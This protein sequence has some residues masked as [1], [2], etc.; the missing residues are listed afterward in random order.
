MVEGYVDQDARHVR[1]KFS[2]TF[3]TYLMPVS[4]LAMGITK[5]WHAELS[6]DPTRGPHDAL[7]PATVTTLDE[8]GAFTSQGLSNR[9]WATSSPIREIFRVAFTSAGLPYF[10]PH[11]LRDMLVRHVIAMDLP[12]ETLK[13]L[14]Q[15]LGHQSLLTTLTSYGSV[16]TQRQGELIKQGFQGQS[17][18][19]N[20]VDANLVAAVVRALQE[21]QDLKR[22]RIA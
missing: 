21:S 10:N 18:N 1:T 4:D 15:N 11:S 20:V 6:S 17:R 9:G 13:S 12:A 14:S 5:Q 8:L 3:R 16:P 2:K 7:F 19:S 22:L